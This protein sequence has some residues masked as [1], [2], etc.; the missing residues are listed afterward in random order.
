MTLFDERERAYENLFAIEEDRRFYERVR[1][2]QLFA[3]W[4][5]ELMGLPEWERRAYVRSLEG[6]ALRSEPDSMLLEQ[7][8][9]DLLAGGVDAPPDALQQA[10]TAAASAA[11]E[12]VRTEAR[13]GNLRALV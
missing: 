10:L 7:V 11:V 9:Q 2:N 13:T 5:A 3:L 8:H 4:A 12:Q 1:R 6:G